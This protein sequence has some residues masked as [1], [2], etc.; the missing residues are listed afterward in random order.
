MNI[1]TLPKRL[2]ALFE[3]EILGQLSDGAWENTY[4]YDHWKFWNNLEVEEGAFKYV[5]DGPW[6]TKRS[7]YNLAKELVTGDCDLSH[8]MRIYTVCEVLGYDKE[9]CNYMEY[10]INERDGTVKADGDYYDF[11]KDKPTLVSKLDSYKHDVVKVLELYSRDALIADLK[12]LR[13]CMNKVLTAHF[14]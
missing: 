11:I 10:A 3:H 13:V 2:K 6:P 5:K 7:G 12:E 8:R 9:V 14:G 1:L 4:P